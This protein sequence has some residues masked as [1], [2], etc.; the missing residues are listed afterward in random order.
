MKLRYNILFIFLF[1][2]FGLSAQTGSVRVYQDARIDTLL[3]K[4][5]QINMMNP[6]IEGFRIQVFFESGNNSKKLANDTRDEF[7]GLFEETSA[8]VLFNE[9]YYKVRVGDFRSRMDAEGALEKISR[10]YPNAFIVPDFIHL[11]KLKE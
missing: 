11:P 9:P 8:Y 1:L 3:D 5:L 6:G 2:G 4:K 7:L 10:E